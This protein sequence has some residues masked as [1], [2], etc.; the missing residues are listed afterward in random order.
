M[1]HPFRLSD[2]ISKEFVGGPKEAAD[3]IVFSE[4]DWGA[5]RSLFPVQ[6]FVLKMFYGIPLDRVNKHIKVTDKFRKEVL[7]DLT[8]WEYLQYLYRQGRCNVNDDGTPFL[9]MAMVMGRRGT[10]STMTSLLTCNEYYKLL[11]IYDPIE[12]YNLMR[13]GEIKFINIANGLN[14]A[15]EIFNMVKNVIGSVP[16]LERYNT[17]LLAKEIRFKTQWELDNDPIGNGT[18]V[19]KTGGSLA[20]S[21]RGGSAILVVLDE[22]AHFVD[23]GGAAS[24]EKVYE[25]LTP[26]VTSFVNREGKQEG[27]IVS[28]SSPLNRSGQLYKLY[29]QG[30]SEGRKSGILVLQI[31][32]W[33]I[34]SNIDPDFLVTRYKRDPS[35]FMTEYG[36]EF[37]DRKRSWIKDSEAFKQNCTIPGKFRTAGIIGQPHFLGIDIGQVNDGTGITVGHWEGDILHTDYSRVYFGKHPT[38]WQDTYD[39]SQQA[40]LS[41]QSLR[42]IAKEVS[43]VCKN[44]YIVKGMFDQYGGLPFL[45]HLKDNGINQ[46][47][48][49]PVNRNINS[50]IYKTTNLLIMEGRVKI[51]VDPSLF[52]SGNKVNMSD[53]DPFIKEILALE[54]TRHQKYQVSV[55]APDI[56]GMHD[57]QADSW[58][59]MCYYATLFKASHGS[60]HILSQTTRESMS[61]GARSHR[62]YQMKK[63]KQHGG[64]D[65]GR[66]LRRSPRR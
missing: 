12:Y 6:K 16:V 49:V 4:A 59:R 65:N 2:I 48:M 17:K 53:S 10:K 55:E 1:Q 19:G 36:A 62:A 26:S 14:A 21:M 29:Q 42:D 64:Y 32:T 63:T 33:E 13:G 44:F 54:E 25:A 8:E 40:V 57:D 52:D 38:G 51:P 31:P 56:E 3:V 5:K 39:F 34:N 43:S 30:M 15:M 20:R 22:I 66:N 35:S 50:E 9:E 46:L 24:S 23:N 27:K 18:I 45:E 7:Y 61:L 41:P 37:S 60:K 11:S 28:L 47:D 58:A